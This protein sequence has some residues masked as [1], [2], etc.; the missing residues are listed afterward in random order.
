MTLFFL[1]FFLLY[2]GLHVYAFLKARAAFAF[3]TIALISISLFMLLMILAPFLIR[4][5]ERHG[6][7]LFARLLSYVGY[8]WLGVLFIFCSIAFVID[9]Y[10]LMVF[11]AGFIS[12][13]DFSHIIPSARYSF[14][15]P[16]LLSLTIGFYGYFEALNIRTEKLVIET[17]KIPKDIGTLRIV[18]ISDVHIGL[19]VREDRIKRIV[20]IIKDAKPDMLVST[21]DLVD[22]QINRLE[23]LADLF[24]EIS[25]KYGKFAITGNH[26]F[27]A[28][29]S[30]ALDFTKKS[31]FVILRA[32]GATVGGLINIVGVDDPAG[33]RY[34]LFEEAQEK[35]LLSRFKNGKFTLFLKHR[36]LVQKDSIGLFDLQLSGHVHKGQIFPFSLITYFYYPLHAGA[37]QF[38]DGSYLYV[39]RGTGTWG[40]P[41]R[42]LSPPEITVIE[43]VH[44]ESK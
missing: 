18:Q 37:R 33:M 28:G 8:T 20:K 25:P 13:K 7:E 40:P 19:I 26:E 16:A 36:P 11:I 21:G 34:S 3:G 31:G 38:E 14:M 43:L 44:K 12:S 35:E 30:Q 4:V 39:S 9:V 22:G 27:Y 15:I 2:S 32:D 41:I 29:L 24:N 1:T 10:K 42:F 6:L 5:S 17:S 23:D